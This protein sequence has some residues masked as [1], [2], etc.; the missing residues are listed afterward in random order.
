MTITA[1][2]LFH[3]GRTLYGNDCAAPLAD[4]LR[5]NLRSMQRMLKQEDLIPQSLVPELLALLRA[6]V[7]VIQEAI[8][9]S[10]GDTP[11]IP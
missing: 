9:A 7:D 6:R 10:S 4:A 11:I 1:N 3:V 8:L 5:I 2:V